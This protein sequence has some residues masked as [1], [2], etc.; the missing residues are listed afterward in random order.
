MLDI[1][2][3]ESFGKFWLFA[4]NNFYTLLCFSV[5]LFVFITAMIA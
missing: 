3:A 4:D 2:Q 5:M 1:F